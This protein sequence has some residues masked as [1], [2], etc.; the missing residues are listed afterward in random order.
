MQPLIHAEYDWATVPYNVRNR[1]GPV[2]YWNNERDFGY[3]GPMVE[4]FNGSGL[5]YGHFPVNGCYV[6]IADSCQ[7]C[8]FW[9][10]DTRSGT[11]RP[12][13]AGEMDGVF[14]V[15]EDWPNSTICEH[16]NCKRERG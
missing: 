13:Y 11:L 7:H 16:N 12:T 8:Y 2:Y 9:L 1:T 10:P 14:Y 4:Y 5:T 6:R 15:W 3:I